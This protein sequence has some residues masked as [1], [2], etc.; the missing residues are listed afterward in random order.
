ML[1]RLSKRCDIMDT[2][3]RIWRSP[4]PSKSNESPYLLLK[5]LHILVCNNVAH[6][7]VHQITDSEIIANRESAV[8]TFLQKN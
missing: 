2:Q 7:L 3:K 8:N 6:I 1:F 5:Y 4:Y